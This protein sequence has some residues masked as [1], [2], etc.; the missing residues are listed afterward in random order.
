MPERKCVSTVI[1]T[2]SQ[3]DNAVANERTL[4]LFE[5]SDSD[6]VDNHGH[7]HLNGCL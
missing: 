1:M 2:H 3:R 5:L 4:W 7:Q 6:L